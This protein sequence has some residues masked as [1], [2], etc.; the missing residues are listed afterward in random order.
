MSDFNNNDLNNN[1][2]D[3]NFI[4]SGKKLLVEDSNNKQIL[5]FPDNDAVNKKIIIEEF[6]KY[7]H[8]NV[9]INEYLIINCVKI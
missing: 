3:F 8:Y 2:N 1:D 9:E 5:Q 6:K 7:V 4:V